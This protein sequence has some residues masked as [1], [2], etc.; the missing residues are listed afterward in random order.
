V[1]ELPEVE[2]VRSDLA[3]IFPGHKLDRLLVTG[4]R[5]VRRHRPEELSCLE[6]LTLAGARRHGKYLLLDW[7]A[8]PTLVVHLRMSG[9]LLA[10]EP[11][12][13][14]APH[15]HAVFYFAG[16]PELHFVDPRTFGELF[17]GA[18]ALAHLGPDALSVTTGELA[19]AFAG[20]RAPVKSLLVNQGV[21]AG[22]GNIYSDEIC[23]RARLRPDRPGGSL[24]R[25]AI[26][27][28]ANATRRVLRAAI[29]GRGS[30]LADR[31]YRDVLGNSGS[32]QGEHKVYGRAGMP[33][34]RCGMA[35]ER[36]HFGARRAFFCAGC[37][38]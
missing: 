19:A 34:W 24:D 27:R 23:F 16:A 20:R 6:G 17:L 21:L 10:V 30:T 36:T 1:P 12:S 33:C 8:G 31:R 11:G 7:E 32:Y 3:G 22:V 5:T 38:A 37:Q 35:I 9:Q 2:T 15:T 4:K 14:R 18:E 13:E 29:T 28:L 26:R 25:A